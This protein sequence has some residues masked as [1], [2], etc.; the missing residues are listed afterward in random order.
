MNGRSKTPI[1]DTVRGIQEKNNDTYFYAVS[2]VLTK[3]T[4]RCIGIGV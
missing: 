4:R 3:M 1:P 2:D